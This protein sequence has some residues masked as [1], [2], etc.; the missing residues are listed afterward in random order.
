[1]R[2][3][4]ICIVAGI[5]L[6]LSVHG[7]DGLKGGNAQQSKKGMITGRVFV[8][9][10]GAME[11]ANVAL[12]KGRD[13]SL[14][15]GTVTNTEGKFEL[16]KIPFGLYYLE[17]DFIGF[18][19]KTISGI[20]INRNTPQQALG[21]LFLQETS[22]NIEGVE[23]TAS[24]PQVRY[25]VD[26]KVIQV[27]QDYTAQ[28]G[29][30]VQVLE[31]VPSIQVDIEGN[32]ELRGSSNFRVLID[33]KPS[34]L[35][36]SEVLQQIPAGMIETIEVVTN[37]SVKYDPE[38]TAGIINV[39]M[40][41]GGGPGLNGMVRA[42]GS[43]SGSL[44]G[45]VNL[46]YALTERLNL[47][48]SIQ[49]RDFQFDMTGLDQRENFGSDTTSY[50][51]Q[52]MEN[53]MNRKSY[54]IEA[55]LDYSITKSSS[56][57]LSGG[58]GS[59]GFGREGTIQTD[60]Y[61]N[62]VSNNTYEKTRSLFDL[63]N[64]Y[65]DVN[66]DYQ[67]HFDSKEHKIN[68]SLYYS[69]SENQD[70]NTSK[71]AQT[72]ENWEP[73]TTGM[74]QFRTHETGNENQL[75]TKID[76][77]LPTSVGKLEA[78]YQGRYNQQN[79]HYTLQNK[80]EGQWI[81]KENAMNDAVFSRQIQ[82]LYTTYSGKLMGVDFQLGI[83][84][85]YTDRLLKQQTL[86]EHYR[87]HRFDLFPSAHFTK[88]F[89]QKDQVFASYSRRI[90]RPGSWYLD[91]FRRFRDQYNARTGNPGL[92]PEYTDSWETGYKKIIGKTVTTLEAYHRN[93]TN[94]IT[95]IQQPADDELMI[96]TVEN[97]QR[98]E[99]TGLE[100]SMN[101]PIYKWWNLTLTGNFYRYSIHGDV[102]EADVLQ[103]GN[104]WNARYS[105]V[106]KLPTGTRVQLTGNYRGPTIT[107][108]GERE[109]F[110]MAGAA[111][112][113]SLIKDQLSLTVN[114]MDLFQGRKR[115]MML[116]G[117]GFENYILRQRESPVITFSL[118]YTINNYKNGKRKDNDREKEYEGIEQM[119]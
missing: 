82:A 80:E 72:D 99:S 45:G 29:S 24:R 60:I 57:S 27:D 117:S 6:S 110:F 12:Y 56:I 41:E 37:P 44:E 97:I 25:Q 20:A 13:S 92:K 93:T 114:G 89:S 74:N 105:S 50:I 55:G 5:I 87:I 119:F 69:G 116:S 7:Q 49:Y 108:Q 79:Y 11:Y 81:D 106:F 62:P 59:F 21:R 36:G 104:H 115:E 96:H 35:D 9:G 75:R 42:S 3:N 112:K 51:D 94:G 109:G 118:S 113:Q 83:R 91:P 33:G 23:V 52:S 107:P 84:G 111:I 103:T 76:Y 14:V 102:V 1:M 26:K 58:L 4:I 47:S 90:N 22:Q 17:V 8:Q 48:S 66:L 64:D 73:V 98:V 19:K 78:G 68:A 18:K 70:I 39:I 46:N 32:V 100:F 88:R 53:A 61:T 28:G 65:Y 54:S 85:E 15:T 31:S 10:D 2:K 71:I 77:V 63:E 30:A 38:G 43:T 34:V 67:K 95:R 40:K 16:R 86:D 101:A